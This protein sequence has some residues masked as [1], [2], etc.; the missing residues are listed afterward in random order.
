MPT[1]QEARNSILKFVTERLQSDIVTSELEIVYDNQSKNHPR[2]G[3]KNW[4]R[5]VVRHLGG[6]D[7]SLGSNRQYKIGNLY[8]QIFT[9]AKT[10]YQYSDSFSDSC[11]K[12]LKGAHT[13]EGVWFRN[14]RT[15]EIGNFNSFFQ[16]NVIS[17]FY[18]E[19][20]Y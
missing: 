19:Q 13:P 5:L 7:S 18:Y 17:E 20:T 10:S 1:I 3:N 9:I 16:T 4:L 2:S 8:I 12:L 11:V 6:G 14:T 15:L